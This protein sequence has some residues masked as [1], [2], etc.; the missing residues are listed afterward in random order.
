MKTPRE[1]AKWIAGRPSSLSI[2]MLR[3]ERGEYSLKS[4]I[5]SS[6]TYPI[7]SDTDLI[8]K[9]FSAPFLAMTVIFHYIGLLFSKI[10]RV[11][12]CL[13]IG[14]FYWHYFRTTDKFL[15]LYP[16]KEQDPIPED[17]EIPGR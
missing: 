1:F 8:A 6:I 17:D 11:V 3:K 14:L 16:Q 4:L 10:L 5:W 13:P 7:D 2:L 15:S 12:F 9:I